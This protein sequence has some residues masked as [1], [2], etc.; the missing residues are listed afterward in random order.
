MLLPVVVA[1]R[2]AALW[3]AAPA[4][5]SPAPAEQPGPPHAAAPAAAPAAAAVGRLR[6]RRLVGAV[7]GRRVSVAHAPPAPRRNHTADRA[8][9]AAAD[10]G[11]QHVRGLARRRGGAHLVG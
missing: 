6:G 3:R 9:V 7:L 4:S 11:H 1:R 5:S 10:R 2:A 8:R